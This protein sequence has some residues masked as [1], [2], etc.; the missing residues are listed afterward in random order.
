MAGYRKAPVRAV[1]VDP[2]RS[3]I[4]PVGHMGYFRPQA[5]ALWNEALDWFD[6]QLGLPPQPAQAAS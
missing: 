1:T 5:R 2:R 6:S 3:G 4:G